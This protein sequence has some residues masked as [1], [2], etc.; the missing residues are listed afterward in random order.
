MFLAFNGKYAFL[1]E[2]L[3]SET[4]VDSAAYFDAETIN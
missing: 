3:F 4:L 2:S 1:E